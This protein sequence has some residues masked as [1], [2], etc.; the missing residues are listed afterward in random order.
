MD[1]A[2]CASFVRDACAAAM[3]N[4]VLRLFTEP[5]L[6]VGRDQRG[7]RST[8]VMAHSMVVRA[9]GCLCATAPK[10]ASRA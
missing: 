2:L 10:W 1:G 8:G 7:I 5:P 9:D 3:K 4:K 6:W